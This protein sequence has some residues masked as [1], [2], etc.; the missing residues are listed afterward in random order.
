[1]INSVIIR[2]TPRLLSNADILKHFQLSL[3]CSNKMKAQLKVNIGRELVHYKI[4]ILF[5][6]LD[7]AQI[8]IQ[9]HTNAFKT[10]PTTSNLWMQKNPQKHNKQTKTPFFQQLFSVRIFTT[11]YPISNPPKSFT[12]HFN[13]N[14]IFQHHHALLYRYRPALSFIL[15]HSTPP[16]ST[17][18][19]PVLPVLSFLH[20]LIPFQPICFSTV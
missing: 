10:P 8:F 6:Y 19:Y 16:S 18:S 13:A 4:H 3:L 2:I 9:A 7:T 5:G 14:F 12:K 20:Y 11:S 15:F 1:M 17:F